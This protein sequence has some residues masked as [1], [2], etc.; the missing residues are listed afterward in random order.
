MTPHKHAQAYLRWLPPMRVREILEPFQPFDIFSA[1][2]LT[3]TFSSRRSSEA[4][5]EPVQPLDIFSAEKGT[6]VV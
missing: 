4:I 3:I 6:P 1:E 2:D 5:M